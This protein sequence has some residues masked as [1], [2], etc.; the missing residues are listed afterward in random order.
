MVSKKQIE[1]RIRELRSILSQK[2]IDA[3]LITKRENYIYM[4]NFTGTFANLLITHDK[5]ILVT[6]FRYTE[7]AKEQ[8]QLY[9]VV[10]YQGNLNVT[11]N[12]LLT[13]N[14]VKILGFEDGY[15]TYKAYDD[16]SKNLSIDKLVPLERTI[17]LLR[18]IKDSEEI[19][20]IKE[21]VRVADEAFSHVLKFIKPGVTETEIAAEI[22]Y[23]LK[24][25][26]ARGPSFDTIVAS[27]WRSSLPHGVASNRVIEHGD[28]VT[29]DF[30]AICNEYC[31]DMTRTVFVGQPKEELKKIYGIVLEAQ[32]AGVNGAVSGLTGREIDKIAR[33]IISDAGY[34]ENFGHSLGHGVG[35]EI[36]EDPRLSQQGTIKMRNGMVVTV[37]PGIYVSG[38]GGVRIEDMIVINDDKP[39]VLTS[40]PKDMIIL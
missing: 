6:D 18:L 23:Y 11:L 40:S 21:A 12:D 17:E 37:E 39:M 9:E 16:L 22:E 38:L 36:H 3:A 14:N 29:M 2:G 27:G 15:I 4:S 10:Q 5:A 19:E 28:A 32:K 26:G 33:D 25:H 35:I 7:Q 20:L 24:K 34:G 13:A 1:R 8:A 30:G 31:S